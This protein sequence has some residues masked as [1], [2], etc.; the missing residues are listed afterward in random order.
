MSGRAC[1]ISVFPTALNLGNDDSFETVVML[2]ADELAR[3][4]LSGNSALQK[5]NQLNS[6][7]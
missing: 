7:Q 3:A 6:V 5:L 4:T 2:Y 1:D